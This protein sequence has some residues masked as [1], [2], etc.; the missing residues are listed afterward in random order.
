[1]TDD[2]SAPPGVA[3]VMRIFDERAVADARLDRFLI[4]GNGGGAALSLALMTRFV[5]AETGGLYP[6]PLFPILLCFLAGLIFSGKSLL[7]NRQVWHNAFQLLQV[8]EP[9]PVRRG[10]SSM[11]VELEPRLLDARLLNPSPHWTRLAASACLVIGTLL[12]LWRLY[13]LADWV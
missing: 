8:G 11:T 2:K 7:I 6:W 1:M 9:R 3:Y 13:L 12:A 4:G 10:S 5:G